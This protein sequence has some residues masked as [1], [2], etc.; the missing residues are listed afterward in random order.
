VLNNI[1]IQ[2]SNAG[3]V[4]FG[5]ADYVPALMEYVKKYRIGLNFGE[6]LVAV[7]GPA[8]KATSAKAWLMAAKK[9]WCVT[10]T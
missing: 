1:D 6:T 5:V 7:D 9:K 4:L 2:F 10:S 8:H 3:A